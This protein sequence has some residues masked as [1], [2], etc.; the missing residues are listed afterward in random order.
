M[1]TRRVPFIQQLG[2]EDCGATCV[3]MV[4]AA[5][6]VHDVAADCRAM[7]GAGRDGTRMRTLASV[8]ARF[9]LQPRVASVSAEQFPSVPLPAVVH[10][11]SS[12]FVVVERCT[13]SSV[14]IVDPALGR[15]TLGRDDFAAGYSGTVLELTPTA[16]LVGRPR[17]WRPLWVDYLTAMFHD[18]RAQGA[19][20]QIVVASVLLQATG[21]ATPLF[22][23]LIVDDVAPPGSPITLTM[24]ALGMGIVLVARTVTSLARTV[25]MVRLQVQ[26]DAQ[27]TEGFFAQLLRL[28]LQFFQGRASGDL[29]LRL[30]S[31]S[32]IRDAL[33]TQLLS[34]LLDGP[35]ALLYLAVLLSIAPSFALLVVGLALLQA[36]LV[37]LSMRPLVDVNQRSLAA[38][39]DEQSCLVELMKG[40][41]HL[42]ASGTEERAFDRWADLFRRQLA[43]S[44][45]RS[46]L[47]AKIEV[48]LGFVRSAS[49][50]VLL[51]YGTTL[52]LSNRLQL[53]TMLAL[54][55]LATAFLTPFLALV[56]S[57]QQ[58]QMLDAYI[59]RLIDVLRA[60]PERRPTVPAIRVHRANA[61]A[62]EVRELSF[63]FSPSG[64]LVVDDVS[65]AVARG[66][67][68]GIV[69]ATGSGKSTI[70]MLLLGLY[71]P[72]SG[73]VLF[74][75]APLSELDPVAVRRRCG[76]VLQD[77]ALFAGTLRSNILLNAPNASAETLLAALR[78]ADLDDD[79][80]R[81]ALRLDTRLSEG[82]TNVSGGQRQRIALAR[83][84]VTEPDILLLDEAT[85][86]LD[87]AAEQR[88]IANLERSECTRIAI[89]HRLTAVRGSDQILVMQ[90][91]RVVERGTHAELVA[92]GRAYATLAAQQD[93]TASG[94]RPGAEG[95]VARALRVEPHG[96]RGCL[97][98][99]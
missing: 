4:L 3:A 8:A 76:V 98:S 11:Q 52:V 31:N 19:L 18:V 62:V 17:S 71:Q 34:V 59:E 78:T 48:A 2:A 47:M 84:V 73:V 15:R 82:G 89:A 13:T 16:Q 36:M 83:A 74:D 99:I 20:T 23:K 94:R 80:T 55:A 65:F 43:A 6:G 32:M 21:L 75:G 22:T 5:H 97:A 86:H 9:E 60:E 12:H 56:Q 14:T 45:D 87:V 91:G 69:G 63:R 54:G 79:V 66:E 58:L 46:A 50:L 40:M 41:V 81:M 90:Q 38:R 7:C 39:T 64:P 77:I 49:P 93:S 26:L 92:L 30:S 67:Q 42:K 10:W 95:G 33:T 51:W 25:V 53:G 57:T 88:V 44:L 29:L 37:L 85:S 61:P 72:T 35:F 70:L 1:T 27:L 68:L 96:H 28:P 24:V